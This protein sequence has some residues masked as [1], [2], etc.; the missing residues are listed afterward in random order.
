MGK[1]IPGRYTAQMEGSFVVFIIGFRINK[2]WAVHKW[3]PVMNSM[4]PMLQELYRNK[5]LGFIDGT[6]HVSWRG[7]TLI[8]Y[9]RSFEQLEHYARHGA[10]HLSAWRRF[11]QA[12][13]TGGDVGIFHETYLV[14][15]GQ[16]E[17]LYNNMPRFGLALAGAHAPAT[18]RRETAG[19]RL[20]KDN[21][22]AVPT[23][24]NRMSP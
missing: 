4:S 22:P 18:G 9:W 6:Y 21:E 5:E 11:N 2:L 23:P 13:G 12:V 16:Y 17:C 24:P 10:N 8:Q 15:E 3:L 7:L 19:R 14:Q 1:V 20:G